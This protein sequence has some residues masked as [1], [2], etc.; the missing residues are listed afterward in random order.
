MMTWGA[1]VKLALLTSDGV[2]VPASETLTRDVFEG[3]LGISQDSDPSFGVE[4]KMVIQ[5]EPALVEYSNLTLVILPV[6]V[7]VTLW[8]LPT[9]Q[10][11]PPLG[12]VTVMVGSALMVKLA[13]LMSEG[14]PL[15][16]SETLTLALIWIATPGFCS[17]REN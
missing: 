12:E 3:V 4:A 15:A 6:E 1:M 10:L 8:L 16:A 2:P 14:V 13:S 9:H 7:Q 11:S 17:G 5:L